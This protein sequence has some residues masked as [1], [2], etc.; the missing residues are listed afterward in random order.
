MENSGVAA[1][2]TYV[3]LL[4]GVMP[5]GKNKVSMAELRAALSEVGLGAVRTY[6]QSG[7]VIASSALDQAAIENLVHD[8]IRDRIGAEITVIARTAAQFRN[9]L[10]RNPLAPGDRSRLY[11]S[12]LASRPEPVRLQ[13]FLAIDFSPDQIL[14]TNDAIYTLYA[15]KYSESRFTNPF[16]ERK[17]NVAIT[18]RNYNTM[19]RL[20]EMS[21][22]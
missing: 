1:L 20:V 16:F 3:I 5:T 13:D 12:L 6:I 17:L 8:V 4:R 21:S 22:K 18:T 10:E 14:F 15:A 9:T 11:F 7:N 19:T 2:N